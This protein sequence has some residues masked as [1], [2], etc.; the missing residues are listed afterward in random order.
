MIVGLWTCG[1]VIKYSRGTKSRGTTLR[2]IKSRGI[3]SRGI[4]SDV[5]QITMDQDNDHTTECINGLYYLQT[6]IFSDYLLTNLKL[7]SPTIIRQPTQK[8]DLQLI[9]IIL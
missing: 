5:D 2:E 8:L 1:L 9:Y 7:G 3:K 4:A 6:S